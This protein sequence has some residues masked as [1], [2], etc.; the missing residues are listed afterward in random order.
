MNFL[1][2]CGNNYFHAAALFFFRDL[3]SKQIAL[4]SVSFAHH[5]LAALC[6][7]IERVS[8]ILPIPFNITIEQEEI[9]E[10]N[11]ENL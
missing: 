6:E 11:T 1:L 4:A 7:R 5:L 10:Q 8:V 3:I 9:L 2:A